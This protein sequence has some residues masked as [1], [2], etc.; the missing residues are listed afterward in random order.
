MVY[1]GSDHRG[2]D[3]KEKLK[4]RFKDLSI[5]LT[6][7]GNNHLDPEDDY[8]IF[9]HRVAGAVKQNPLSKGIVLCG[10]GAGVDMVANKVDGIRCAL[11]FDVARSI[12]ARQHEDANM[13]ALPADTLDEETAYQIVKAFLET[14]FSGE[15]RHVRRLEELKEV[16]DKHQ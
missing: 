12:Q 7:L 6:D 4:E 16:E 1:I 5:K 10:S 13:V 3:L 14:P 11:V 15:M 2:F 8:V 9:S